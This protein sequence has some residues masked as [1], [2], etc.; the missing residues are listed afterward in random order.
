MESRKMLQMNLFAKQ[1]QRYRHKEWM[2]GY[3]GAQEQKNE[4]GD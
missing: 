1:K 2:Y 4:L 3:K